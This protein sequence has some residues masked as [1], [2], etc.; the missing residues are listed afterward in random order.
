MYICRAEN[1]KQL[2]KYK[3]WQSLPDM[4]PYLDHMLLCSDISLTESLVSMLGK[5][6]RS[7]QLPTW[8]DNE[9]L[10]TLALHNSWRSFTMWLQCVLTERPRS[11]RDISTVSSRQRTTLVDLNEMWQELQLKHML[12]LESLGSSE[13]ERPSLRICRSFISDYQ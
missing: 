5:P 11:Y 12:E 7:F 9:K 3:H 2:L 4:L 1:S 8:P 6:L 10:T 13:W